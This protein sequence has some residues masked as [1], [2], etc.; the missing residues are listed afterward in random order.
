MRPAMDCPLTAA[1]AGPLPHQRSIHHF[2]GLRL[3]PSRCA[4]KTAIST[5]LARQWNSGVRL[6]NSFQ[7]VMF[8][9]ALQ[10]HPELRIVRMGAADHFVRHP[11]HILSRN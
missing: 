6:L 2:N 5:S 8:V 10:T 4:V 7:Q 9:L 11:G 1:Q 3:K